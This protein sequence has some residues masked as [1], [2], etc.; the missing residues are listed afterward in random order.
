MFGVQFYPVTYEIVEQMLAPLVDP[1]ES[2]ELGRK[3]LK[4]HGRI[5][6]PQA[7]KGDMFRHLAKF[8]ESQDSDRYRVLYGREDEIPDNCYAA[9]IDISLRTLLQSMDDLTV[10]ASDWFEYNE[11]E[12][13]DLILSNPPFADAE[14]HFFQSLR[15]LSPGGTLVQ[16]CNAETLRNPGTKE[17]QRLLKTVALAWSVDPDFYAG[18]TGWID[19]DGA[20]GGLYALL[21]ALVDKGALEWLGQPFKQAERSTAVEVACLWVSR[22]KDRE[23][24]MDWASGN[25]ERTEEQPQD[26]RAEVTALTSPG[27][28]KALVARYDAAVLLLEQR[29]KKSAELNVLLQDVAQ[30]CEGRT[31][32]GSDIEPRKGYREE[33]SVLKSMFWQTVFNMTELGSRLGSK[34]QKKF[35]DFIRCQRSIQFTER[36]IT[37]LV[38][39]LLADIDGMMQRLVV[40][41]FDEMTGYHEDNKVHSE[42]WKTNAPAKIKE[43]RVILP[44]GVYYE[45]T[46]G[47]KV[48]SADF[49]KDLDKA[50]CW[51]AGLNHDDLCKRNWTTLQSVSAHC[52]KHSRWH[53]TDPGYADKF[54]SRF[55]EMRM[56][57]KGTLHLLFRDEE[58]AK[59]FAVAAADGRRWI[60]EADGAAAA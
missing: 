7:G 38:Q 58:L 14:A 23:Q 56:F 3:C 4:R 21:T 42:G 59:D 19:E 24:T 51:V 37:E 16:L 1:E 8:L 48:H 47:F 43:R 17:R 15:F 30:Y 60:A 36:N 45:D 34:D 52:S 10:I 22:P 11:P 9:E 13:F 27:A 26:V 35:T 33:H 46:W 6:D 39:M 12:D 28:I 50:L 40:N 54:S 2:V 5:L 29:A 57:K 55:F 44:R 49:L 25:F 53:A 31:V 32:S 18:V 20:N 41:V